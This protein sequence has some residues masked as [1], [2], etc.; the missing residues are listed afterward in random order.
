[1]RNLCASIGSAEVAVSGPHGP[2]FALKLSDKFIWSHEEAI[3]GMIIISYEI[4][5]W[6][7]L[8]SG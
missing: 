3:A 8:A 6:H 4:E 5:G 7:N 2:L 1:M